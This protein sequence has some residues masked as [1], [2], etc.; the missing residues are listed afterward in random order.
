MKDKEWVGFEQIAAHCKKLEIHRNTVKKYL[1]E[2]KRDGYVEQSPDGH[3]PYR[4]TEQGQNKVERMKLKGHVNGLIDKMGLADI[5]DWLS[6]FKEYG[7]NLR[8]TDKIPVRD[9]DGKTKWKGIGL[10]FDSLGHDTSATLII[11]EDWKKIH[12][13]EVGKDGKTHLY[14]FTYHRK[15]KD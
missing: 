11:Y 7:V 1:D 8:F 12:E 3:H 14:A 15:Q 6:R 13:V 4:L 2:V 9:E 5:R 10:S